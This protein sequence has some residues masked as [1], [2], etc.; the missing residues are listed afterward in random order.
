MRSVAYSLF[1]WTFF[2]WLVINHSAKIERVYPDTA[3]TFG[4][5]MIINKPPSIQRSLGPGYQAGGR[6]TRWRLARYCSFSWK[7]KKKNIP[8][9]WSSRRCI[10]SWGHFC[11]F[12]LSDDQYPVARESRVWSVDWIFLQANLDHVSNPCY[13]MSC[14]SSL[15]HELYCVPKISLRC[16][17]RILAQGLWADLF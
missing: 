12:S 17:F 6:R 13:F 1:A 5:C 11:F 2:R 14:C 10:E 9:I 3:D 4:I 7:Q 16:D 8:R 15:L